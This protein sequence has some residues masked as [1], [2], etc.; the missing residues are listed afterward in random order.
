MKSARWPSVLVVSTSLLLILTSCY[1]LEPPVQRDP[2][3]AARDL[4]VEVADLPA[5]W[6]STDIYTI[7]AGAVDH[8]GDEALEVEFRGPR[9]SER[10]DGAYHR[11][12]RFKNATLAANAYQRMQR[13][14][15]FF[16]EAEDYASHPRNWQYRSLV[17]DD[18]RFACTS[19]C[20]V[21]ARYG[22]FISVFGTSMTT[23]SMTVEAFEAVL[24]A[25]DRRM[26][27]K[28]GKA[29]AT[30]ASASR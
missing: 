1:Y 16:A 27:D 23:S 21:I 29:E 22:E 7:R 6:R 20:G 3:V 30:P 11:V 13:D 9:L 25:I 12:Y 26:A 14:R 19:G 15:Y 4:L 8:E 17:A 24:R 10:Q 5:A 28:L 18:W 2:P